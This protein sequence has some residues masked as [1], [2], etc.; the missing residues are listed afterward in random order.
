M[1]FDVNRFESAL[2][3]FKVRIPDFASQIQ[4]VWRCKGTRG[5][6]AE[7]K[8]I[9]SWALQ[10]LSGKPDYSVPWFKKISYGGFIIPV[11]YSSVFRPLIKHLKSGNY[12]EI[13]RILSYLNVYHIVDGP[14]P[15]DCVKAVETAL[16]PAP[17]V[18]PESNL[19]WSS[20]LNLACY[21]IP[22]FRDSG[23]ITREPV[24]TGQT[25]AITPGRN[26]SYQKY[27]AAG[28][29][30]SVYE[31]MRTVP[32]VFDSG[33][34]PTNRPLF[35]G[36]L[37]FI[38]DTGGKTRLI[39]IGTPIVQANLLEFQKFLM[40]Q[41][42]SIPTDCT[43]D[44][45]AGV[46][47]LKSNL[48]AR[49]TVYS[50]D[51]SDATWNFPASLQR[52]VARR[53]GLTEKK[54]D[55]IFG[56]PVYNP[57]K[58]ELAF[59]EKGQAMGLNPSF[60]LFALCHNLVLMGIC[61]SIGVSPVRTFRVLGDDVI[62]TSKPVY[63]R[64]L[65]FLDCYSVPVSK[66]KTFESSQLGEFAGKIIL[67]GYDVTPIKWKRLVSQSVGQ[68]YHDYKKIGR[69]I[70][71]SLIKGDG[72]LLAYKV[73]GP[74]PRQAGGL[75]ISNFD[76][77]NRLGGMRRINQLR[78]GY[79]ASLIEG[80]ENKI[81]SF[82]KPKLPQEPLEEVTTIPGV[83]DGCPGDEY[84]RKLSG[85]L[86]KDIRSDKFGVLPSMAPNP[87]RVFSQLR[88]VKYL[89]PVRVTMRPSLSKIGRHLRS[90]VTWNTLCD[91]WRMLR[92]EKKKSQA[93]CQPDIKVKK[94]GGCFTAFWE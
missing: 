72:A 61:R 87:A 9:K 40:D 45:N 50:V 59:V 84:L 71:H 39:L 24:P 46:D 2:Q 75:G 15:P 91:D 36:N 42:R 54:L 7:L 21:A 43:F 8:A 81:T 56:F 31:D 25:V 76:T 35:Q 3:S 94:E 62:I 74:I 88:E 64:Y 48:R 13:R 49:N 34:Y 5:L 80:L 38:G 52:E 28:A 93:S 57:L 41:L 32:A 30:G 16:Q 85:L 26:G 66:A 20:L 19:Y 90:T 33:W 78:S 14:F 86:Q 60:P 17:V 92:Y 70:P 82:G 65:K 37:Q 51:L 11:R 69:G 63:Q 44:Q 23:S 4:K 83:Y 53:I 58:K 10:I 6:V 22:R 67:R 27:V 77:T 18:D 79:M 68:L 29:P 12:V 73:L 89:F 47:F 1:Q 55:F